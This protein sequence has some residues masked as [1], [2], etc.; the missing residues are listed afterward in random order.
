MLVIRLFRWLLFWVATAIAI[1]FAISNDGAVVDLVLWPLPGSMTFSLVVFSA[2]LLLA[3][4][5]AGLFVLALARMRRATQRVKPV[6]RDPFSGGAA[7]RP[8]VSAKAIKAKKQ[9]PDSGTTTEIL[10]SA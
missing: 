1:S 6:N 3:G 7:V 9:V 2:A 4:F 5:L 10:P 8:P